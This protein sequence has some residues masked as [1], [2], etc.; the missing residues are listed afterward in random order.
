MEIF[1]FLSGNWQRNNSHYIDFL[2]KMEK[3]LAMNMEDLPEMPYTEEET[4]EFSKINCSYQSNFWASR[5]NMPILKNCCFAKL[6]LHNKCN[7]FPKIVAP[8]KTILLLFIATLKM[9]LIYS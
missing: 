3:I 1:L 4:R 7:E 8:N 9:W 6:S 2:R 5:G